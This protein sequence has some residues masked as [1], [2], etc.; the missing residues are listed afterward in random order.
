MST[1]HK[2]LLGLAAAL[3][4]TVGADLAL[5]TANRSTQATIAERSTFIQ[6]SVALERLNQDIVRALVELAARTQ[7][8]D[9][10]AL[11]NA[12]GITF[13]LALPGASPGAS[14]STPA[15]QAPAPAAKG[16]K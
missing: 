7:D 3:A 13:N 1:Q 14:P 15:A 6:Q 16:S 4:L 12:N 5:A 10:T 9:V 8:K 2:V 11:L